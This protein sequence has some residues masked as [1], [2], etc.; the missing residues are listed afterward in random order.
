MKKLILLAF[1][2]LPLTTTGCV[3]TAIETATDAA[4]AVA[5]VPFKVVG[6]AA[7]VVTDDDVDE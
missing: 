1:I 7:D 3:G 6:A 5:K 2:V 4:I